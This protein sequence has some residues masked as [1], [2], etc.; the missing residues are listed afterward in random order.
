MTLLL[1]GCLFLVVGT[2][3]AVFA[4]RK[5]RDDAHD[6][7]VEQMTESEV[8][9]RGFKAGRELG[10]RE[11]LETRPNAAIVHLPALKM[12]TAHSEGHHSKP[13][14]ACGWCSARREA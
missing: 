13:D 14:A 9:A 3:V 4:V 1:L 6:W 7:Y 2:V 8:Y 12:W 10:R 11:G 5:I